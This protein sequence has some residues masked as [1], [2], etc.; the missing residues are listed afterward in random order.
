M[1][2]LVEATLFITEADSDFIKVNCG[3][4]FAG[5]RNHSLDSAQSPYQTRGGP[6]RFSKI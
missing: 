5:R 1:C 2:H 4:S 6:N 3:V